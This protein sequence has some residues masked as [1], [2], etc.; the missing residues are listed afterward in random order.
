M[1]KK[2]SLPELFT[3]WRVLLYLFISLRIGLLIVY[4]PQLLATS[5]AD[6]P[7]VERG[8]TTL[9]DYAEHYQI[10]SRVASD[11]LPYK[12][13][14]VEFPPVWPALTALLATL[15]N[16]F[17]N[18][19]SVL[20]LLM[21][22]FDIGNL[23]LVRQ[24]GEK[25][26]GSDTG[27]ALSWVYALLVTPLVMTA[28]NFES[29]V[30]FTVLMGFRWLI[31]AK[32]IPSAAVISFG[33]LT[34]YISVLILPVVW[35]FYP[36]CQ[37]IIFSAFSL[38]IALVVLGAL[39]AW[40]GEIAWTSL[41]VQFSK[42]SYQ[43]VWALL[44]GNYRTGSFPGGEAR[45]D[46]EA[47]IVRQWGNEAVIPAWLRLIPF[48]AFG[49]WLFMRPMAD[50]ISTQFAFLSI[51]LVIFMLWSHGWSPQWVVVLLPFILLNFP[52]RI[53]V[54]GAVTLMIGTFI[55]YPLL[56]RYGAESGNLISE[57]YRLPF[58]LMIVARTLFLGGFAA[59]LM[60]K[61]Q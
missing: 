15:F 14:W 55:E 42:P 18:W 57:A 21:T 52:T 13:Y 39:L 16:N 20:F 41:T 5:D 34:K 10:S 25:L 4:Q 47:Q 37:A 53:G 9:G 33:I 48:A 19:A 40:G 38:G 32:N 54:L 7:L 22:L 56:F 23:L 30:I 11:N 50:K 26:H 2:N 24:L 58:A 29:I 6:L 51:T 8:L 60:G 12:D 17:T 1:S 46:A 28:W 59:A 36:R 31:Q 61:L 43:T 49:L 44:D 35:K 3:D 45:Y 27:I